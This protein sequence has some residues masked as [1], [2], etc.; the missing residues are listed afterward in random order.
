MLAAVLPTQSHAQRAMP[1]W[2]VGVEGAVSF[3]DEAN[4]EI[5]SR[6]VIDELDF[7]KGYGA[8]VNLGYAP[9]GTRTLLDKMRFEIEYYYRKND[10]EKED[11]LRANGD[12]TS[13]AAML[14]A[15]YDIPLRKYSQSIVPYL[16]AGI[17]VAE[18][19]ID[20]ESL[21][22]NV[23]DKDTVVAWNF[24]AGIGY[25]PDFMP[26]TMWNIGYRYFATE[27][28]HYR[29]QPTPLFFPATDVKHEYEVHNFEAGV[30]YLF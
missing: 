13:K 18:T 2:Y 6:P 12:A 16:G 22:L 26:N 9:G 30:R 10:I 19:E 17:G 8:G 29:S 28:P 23:K 14:N 11:V 21:I 25:T 7:D 24:M 4:T 15:Y 5:G 20:V 27:D 1:K 3:V